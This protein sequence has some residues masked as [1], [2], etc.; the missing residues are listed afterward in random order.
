MKAVCGPRL[1]SVSFQPPNPTMQT[2]KRRALISPDERLF[3]VASGGQPGRRRGDSKEVEELM[4]VRSRRLT[5]WNVFAFMIGSAMALTARAKN[6]GTDVDALAA[7][8][9]EIRKLRLA[10]E[11]SA[12]SQAQTQVL[13]VYLSAQPRRLDQA[14]ARWSMLNE[15]NLTLQLS[16]TRGLAAELSKVSTTDSCERRIR[17]PVRRWST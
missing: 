16:D 7:V 6:D 15:G 1:F 11:D 17:K 10:M 8:T 2:A 4:I 5:L 9:A 3:G 13:G 12:R 14:D